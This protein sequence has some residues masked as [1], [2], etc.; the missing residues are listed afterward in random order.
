VD[1]VIPATDNR[2][3]VPTDGVDNPAKV[4]VVFVLF[5]YRV[6]GVA[7]RNPDAENELSIKLVVVPVQ[8]IV[9]SAP[10]R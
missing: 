8:S 9:L 5:A 6:A 3:V 10:I 2:K 7:D 4:D 1:P